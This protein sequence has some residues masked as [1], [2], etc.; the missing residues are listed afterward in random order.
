MDIPDGEALVEL[1]ALELLDKD[2]IAEE[3]VVSDDGDDVWLVVVGVAE[4][5]GATLDVSGCCDDDDGGACVVVGC[6]G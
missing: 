3:V 6:T 2:S 5:V 1:E 4:V